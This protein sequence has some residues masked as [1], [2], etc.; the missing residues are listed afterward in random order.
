[1]KTITLCFLLLP[2]VL[3]VASCAKK[4]TADANAAHD[5]RAHEHKAPH[6]GTPVVLGAET[7]HLELVLD[8]SAGKLRAYVL[9]AEMENYIRLTS[10]SFEVIATVAGAK[11]TLAFNAVADS[12]TGE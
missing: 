5:H 9:D 10:P 7:Y 6:N 12:A 3:V 8:S 4:K 11:Q 1:M 2:A